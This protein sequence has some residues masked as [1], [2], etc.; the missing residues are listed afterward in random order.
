MQLPPSG[1]PPPLPCCCCALLRLSLPASSLLWLPASLR[2]ALLPS[3]LRRRAL[4]SPLWSR[5]VATRRNWSELPRPSTHTPGEG[6]DSNPTWRGSGCWPFESCPFRP[7][8]VLAALARLCF[9]FPFLPHLPQL[10]VL[11]CMAADR[12]STAAKKVRRPISV[13][14]SYFHGFSFDQGLV[15]M[16]RSARAH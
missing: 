9:A 15:L 5:S 12:S 10:G 4:R 14:R 7:L 8:L 2:F 13:R 3:S 6:G 11:Q 1:R 16:L